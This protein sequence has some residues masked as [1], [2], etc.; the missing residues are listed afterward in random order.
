MG[1]GASSSSSEVPFP[2]IRVT[3]SNSV[4]SCLERGGGGKLGEAERA[5]NDDAHFVFWSHLEV[6]S[7]C[8]GQVLGAL[9]V[10]FHG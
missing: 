2:D 6:I 7:A 4:V 3:R 10:I 9:T 8:F 1:K 5:P